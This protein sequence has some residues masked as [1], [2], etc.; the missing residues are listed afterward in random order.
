MVRLLISEPF[1]QI[2]VLSRI[3]LAPIFKQNRWR[4]ETDIQKPKA[5]AF[6]QFLK[7]LFSRTQLFDQ[8]KP[9][10]EFANELQE[11]IL[12]THLINSSS[13]FK[14]NGCIPPP[15]TVF[16][17]LFYKSKVL[18]FAKSPYKHLVIKIAPN[19][20]FCAC[21]SDK[22]TQSLRIY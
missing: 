18:F 22:V 5:D 20:C 2:R 9:C 4:K 17:R 6:D 13:S 8:T 19:I 12:E 7:M 21:E 16:E 11:E 3:F 1:C 10:P 14:E 15:T